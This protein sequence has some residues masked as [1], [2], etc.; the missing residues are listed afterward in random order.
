MSVRITATLPLGLLVVLATP[1]AAQIRASERGATSQTVDGTVITID[2]ARPQIRGRDSVFA[3]K[4]KGIVYW[5]EVWTPGANWASTL[6]VSK[7]VTL[8]GHELAAGKYSVW[9]TPQQNEWTIALHSNARLFHTAP[10]KDSTFLLKF[11]VTPT[12][13]DTRAEVLQFSFPVV[14]QTGTTLRMHWDRTW[15]DVA[16]GVRPSRPPSNLTAAQ[17]APFLGSFTLKEADDTT[18]REQKAEVIAAGNELRIVVDGWGN[19]TIGLLP[20]GEH[21]YT[22]AFLEDGQVRDVEEYAE[23][24]FE[25]Q[26]GRAVGFQILDLTENKPWMTARRRAS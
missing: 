19:Y 21:R 3:T 12:A 24:V 14:T 5:G 9:F 8:N 15:V 25:M 1:P 20:K 2:Y 22:T 6:E 26:G 16:V 7:P 4:G 18:G 11:T 23:V 17:M 10:P 13:A